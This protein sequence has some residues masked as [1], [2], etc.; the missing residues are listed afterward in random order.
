[1]AYQSVA[2]IISRAAKQ[3]GL[4]AADIV[5]PY[6]SADQS[7]VQM[8]E[9]LGD[10][11]R[12]I[13]KAREWTFLQT[14]YTFNTV[15]GQTLYPLPADFRTKTD[16]TGWNRSTRFPLGGPMSAQAWQYLKA[17]PTAATLTVLFRPRNGQIEIY[18]P[19]GATIA[20]IAFEYL[21]TYW[22]A[23][24]GTTAPAKSQ[25]T[26]KDDILLFDELLLVRAVKLAWK[27][28]KGLDTTAAQQDYDQALD[29]AMD[30]D[31]E[32]PVLRIDGRGNL[33]TRLLSDDNAPYGNFN[34]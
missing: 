23:T 33:R 4:V 3:L 8:L 25:P 16:Q 24:V 20:T 28:E 32:A 1:M 9:L 10:A 34:Q 18:P 13:C 17:L 27:R 7:I 6:A 11:G 26:A 31:A 5:D 30:D 2:T 29:A 14:E 15:N 22:V 21:T 19:P 12:E